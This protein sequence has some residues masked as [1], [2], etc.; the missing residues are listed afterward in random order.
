MNLKSSKFKIETLG[1]DVLLDGFTTGESW[2][3]W[4]C[5]YFTYEQGEKVV[6][7]FKAQKTFNGKSFVA[8][9]D[10]EK[11]AFCFKLDYEN[12]IEE[13]SAIEI[14]G[15]KLYPVLKFLKKAT[16]KG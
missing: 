2:N 3:G 13:F 14:E 7:A 9:Y 11:D 4:D 16:K 10:S 15:K 12:E 8:F 5:P 1:P 6:K